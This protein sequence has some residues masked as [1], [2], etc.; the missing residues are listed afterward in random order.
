MMRSVLVVL[1]H[2]QGSEESGKNIS[3]SV[4]Y[5]FKWWNK[6]AQAQAILF[7][8]KKCKNQRVPWEVK[9]EGKFPQGAL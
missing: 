5:S 9:V 7:I 2:D 6:E 4:K 1:D 8:R 3:W